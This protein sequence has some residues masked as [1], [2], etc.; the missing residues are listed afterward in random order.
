MLI[1]SVKPIQTRPL[2][3]VWEEEEFPDMDKELYLPE[4]AYEM[5]MKDMKAI[6]DKKDAV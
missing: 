4:D 5:T 6:Y 3:D 1:D 2:V